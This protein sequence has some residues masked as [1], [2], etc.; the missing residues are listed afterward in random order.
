MQYLGSH[1]VERDSK[2]GT[3]RK[4]RPLSSAQA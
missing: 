4:A 2:Q 3:G 1:Q